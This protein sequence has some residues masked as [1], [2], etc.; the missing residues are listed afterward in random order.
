MQYIEKMI[1]I[2]YNIHDIS[3]KHNVLKHDVFKIILTDHLYVIN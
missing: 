3:T 1:H 2:L